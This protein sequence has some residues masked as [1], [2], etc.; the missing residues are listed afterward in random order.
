MADDDAAPVPAA[1]A[2]AWGLREQPV[3]GPRPGVSVEK[4]VEAAIRIADADG[5]PAVSMSKVAAELG[6]TA[7]AL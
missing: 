5:L 6:V 7:M 3:K 1:I 4:I 2:A